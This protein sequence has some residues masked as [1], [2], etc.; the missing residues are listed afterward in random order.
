LRFNGGN[1]GAL[2]LSLCWIAIQ[3]STPLVAELQ[4]LV[5]EIERLASENLNE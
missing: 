2:W 5:E 1:E 4:R 3:T